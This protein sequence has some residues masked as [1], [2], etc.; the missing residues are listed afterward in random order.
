[1]RHYFS[2]AVAFALGMGLGAGLYRE[3]PFEALDRQRRQLIN[4]RL[5]LIDQARHASRTRDAEAILVLAQQLWRLREEWYTPEDH[6]LPAPCPATLSEIAELAEQVRDTT[7][8]PKLR[9]RAEVL[10]YRCQYHPLP[11]D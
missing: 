3:P 10:L 9:R 7:P 6:A 2:W 4:R 1:V 8:D 5:Q 11:E